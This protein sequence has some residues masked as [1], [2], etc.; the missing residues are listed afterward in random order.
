MTHT[1]VPG[2][3]VCKKCGATVQYKYSSYEC[4]KNGDSYIFPLFYSEITVSDIVSYSV[5]IYGSFD[6]LTS[7]ST[8]SVSLTQASEDSDQLSS[9][10]DSGG[11][12]NSNSNNNSTK[13]AAL[14]V[15]LLGNDIGTVEI[16]NNDN[17]ATPPTTAT[18]S[19]DVTCL[20]CCR[21]VNVSRESVFP[22]IRPRD[23]Y[24]EI[25]PVMAAATAEGAE[26]GGGM[27]QVLCLSHVKVFFTYKATFPTPKQVQPR[28]APFEGGTYAVISGD[29]FRENMN[30]FCCLKHEKRAALYLD[31]HHVICVI[32]PL[33]VQRRQQS[34]S[35]ISTPLSVV[36]ADHPDFS[37]ANLSMVL[38]SGLDIV[39]YQQPVIARVTPASAPARGRSAA[40]LAFNSTLPSAPLLCKFQ[41]LTSA[42]V[43]RAVFDDVSSGV[44]VLCEVPPWS[45]PETARL[46]VT[47][48]G[49]QYNAPVEFVFTETS[50]MHFGDGGSRAFLAS[51]RR[52]A[53]P[54]AVV[55]AVAVVAFAGISAV[56]KNFLVTQA[57]FE[58]TSLLRGNGGDGG[59]GGSIAAAAPSRHK[60]TRGRKS[61]NNNS[62]GCV[63]GNGSIN[64]ASGDGND[65]GGGAD[66]GQRLV[67]NGSEVVFI[68]KADKETKGSEN[69]AK[70]IYDIYVGKWK[71]SL[72]R[73]KRLRKEAVCEASLRCFEKEVAALRSLRSPVIIGYFGNVY[74][75]YPAT[76]A[77]I[78]EHMELGSLYNVLHTNTNT[79][80]ITNTNTNPIEWAVVL[81]ML[82]D[83][84]AAVS[85]LHAATSSSA[86][87]LLNMSSLSFLV[88][89]NYQV[90]L[91]SLSSLHNA[92]K[93]S[94][95]LP[96]GNNSVV[97]N[98]WCAPEVL[99][100]CGSVTD[101]ADTY[102]FGMIMWEVVSKQ[103]PFFGAAVEEVAERVV[104]EVLRPEI[105]IWCPW[106]YAELVQAC[107]GPVPQRRP[108]FPEVL[109]ALDSLVSLGW[110]GAPVDS[111]GDCSNSNS[112]SNSISLSPSQSSS[113]SSHPNAKMALISEGKNRKVSGDGKDT[114][115]CLTTQS[116]SSSSSSSS[117]SLEFSSDEYL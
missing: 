69:G 25:T 104:K 90:K 50:V 40:T 80:T 105:P 75:K 47:L 62:G 51:M 13:K 22:E 30:L 84:A 102:S 112:N 3:K 74:T 87:L 66:G 79:N 65:C 39:Y 103:L 45:R 63:S 55:V 19:S 68:E 95:A 94:L 56:R 6:A 10:T 43:V 38:S 27:P 26:G 58:D 67:L 93:K 12:G 78:T 82:K 98:L 76:Y 9:T 37:K 72:V 49:Q 109:K 61:K 20:N 117:T 60:A 113:T 11:S 17:N 29:N 36:F 101:K 64:S 91:A 59:G 15:T 35:L 33:P 92:P 5:D 28:L 54:V 100:G 7:L 31:P 71:G 44:S 2:G 114:K 34:T 48:N 99:R 85:Y 57:N 53:V 88:S 8:P 73:V 107:W 89:K 32:P 97:L 41:S 108:S 96:S 77:I 24:L 81:R 46:S 16:L 18:S 14:R 23:N 42:K 83:I 1:E 52:I 21:H 110:T 106:Q 4:H 115:E 86:L 70:R 116:D 111:A